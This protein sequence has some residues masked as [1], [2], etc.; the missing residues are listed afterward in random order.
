MIDRIG[1]WGKQYKIFGSGADGSAGWVGRRREE[2]QGMVKN[3]E[4]REGCVTMGGVD[5]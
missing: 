4:Q 2:W 5:G 1:W 3:G